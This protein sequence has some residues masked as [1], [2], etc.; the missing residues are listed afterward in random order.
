MISRA[1]ATF[2]LGIAIL[3]GAEIE[4]PPH[5]QIP[6]VS[7]AP[8]IVDFLEG[9]PREAETKITGFRQ[10]E[11]KDGEPASRE[12]TVYLSY[13]NKNLYA[14]FICAEDPKQIRAHIS[15]RESI[16]NDDLAGIT[17]DTFHDG[18]RAYVFYTNPYG[19]QVDGIATEGQQDDYRFDAVWHSEG[20]ITPDG[21]MVLMAIPFRS[22]RFSRQRDRTW[23]IALTR[24][25]PSTN[26]AATWPRITSRI[27]AYIP[28]FA[29]LEALEEPAPGRNIQL[30]P[31]G[32]FGREG[33]LAAQPPDFFRKQNEIRGGIDAK[34]TFRNGLTL[35]TTANPDFSQVETDE[36]Q[37]TVNQRYEVFFPERRPFFQDNAGFFQ[38]PEALFF[39]RRIIQPQVG[40]K[41]TGKV[42]EWTVGILAMDDRA[43]GRMLSRNDADFGRRAMVGVARVQRDLGSGSSIGLLATG[44]E[45]GSTANYVVSADTR[46]KVNPN[47]IFTGQLMRSDQRDGSQSRTGLASFT[48]IRHA[49]R[50][51]NY[52]TNY[53]WRT[54]EFRADLGYMPRVDLHQLKNV[55]GYKWRPEKGPLLSFGPAIFTLVNYDHTGRLQDWSVNTPVY[56]D[57]KGPVTVA[58]DTSQSYE[59]YQSRG[60]R[61]SYNTIYGS[62]DRWKWMSLTASF[63]RGVSVNY[64]PAAGL[65]PFAGNSRDGLLDLTFRPAVRWRLNSSYLYSRLARDRSVVYTNHLVRSKV[66]YQFTRALSLR[67]IAD[68]EAVLADPKLINVDR[69]KRIRT[70]VLATYM[71]NPWTALYAG[72]GD[73]HEN[74][75]WDEL[76]IRTRRPS[77]LT[78]RQ[79]FVKFSY[80]IRF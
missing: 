14:V 63:T 30:V 72:Y 37:V 44:R 26:E 17:L 6:K 60:F 10:R 5:V 54:P 16:G 52:Y 66:G 22:L 19:I 29:T 41:L 55:A 7:R 35:D 67:F 59:F 74:L 34:F 1:I 50:R 32:F 77:L 23:G 48:E 79:L 51:L 68:Y 28:Q 56:F 53:R 33:F 39:S 65:A 20:R 76:F 24:F 69:S 57:F 18:H 73:I 12:T 3:P 80:L 49:G 9:R 21:Y 11:P 8:R 62:F 27:D 45:F 78:G 40:A 64:Y 43:P 36:P 4:R 2:A 42:G 15:R 61:K 70:D 31:Y 46:W 71:L 13:D 58:A 75:A 25:I 38:T 47:W